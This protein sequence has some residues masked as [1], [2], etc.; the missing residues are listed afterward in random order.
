MD[1]QDRAKPR[2]LG[3]IQSGDIQIS[4]LYFKALHSGGSKTGEPMKAYSTPKLV[5]KMTHYIV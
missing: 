2:K 4:L 5:G 1:I 3:K